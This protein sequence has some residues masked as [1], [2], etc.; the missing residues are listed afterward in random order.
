M[1]KNV[2]QRS[3]KTLVTGTFHGNLK[4]ALESVIHDEA[5]PTV[6]GSK[7]GDFK[8]WVLLLFARTIFICVCVLGGGGGVN[9]ILIFCCSIA[10]TRG[11]FQHS[12]RCLF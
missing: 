11:L 5:L 8:L 12:K 10:Y 1:L 6:F 9:K 4:Q 7:V 2:I 3:T